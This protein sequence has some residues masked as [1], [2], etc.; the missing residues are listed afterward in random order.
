MKK[1]PQVAK[2]KVELLV[3][4]IIYRYEND[5]ALERDVFEN[6]VH[7][8]VKEVEKATTEKNEKVGVG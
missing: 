4:N 3:E 7:R 2:T 1:I 8:L 5:S 6:L